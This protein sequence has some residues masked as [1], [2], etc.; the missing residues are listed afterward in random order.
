[1]TAYGLLKLGFILFAALGGLSIVLSLIFLKRLTVLSKIVAVMLLSTA[2]FVLYVKVIE[3][4]WIQVTR[5]SIEDEG[6]QR[7]AKDLTI[8]QISDIHLHA[9]IGWRE[10][11][12]VSM[13]N[14]LEPDIILFTG[15]LMDDRDQLSDAV[16]L[17]GGLR[18]KIGVFGVAGDT[19]HIVMS[20]REFQSHMKRANMDVLIN[21]GRNIKLPN[22]KIL[23]LVGL[24]DA[25]RDV[26]SMQRALESV[27]HGVFKIV[28]A[29][30]P[31]VF[32]LVSQYGPSLLL[33][34]DTHGGQ[35]G[36][37]FLI[38]ASD[39]AY[40][41]PYMRGLFEKAGTKMYVNRGIGMTTL[42]LRF[43]CRPE[44]LEI[45]SD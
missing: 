18:A 9:G 7:V 10:N 28:I 2:L 21:E 31:D 5:L 17:I 34:G 41:T 37:D 4:N 6:F 27:P 26:P 12:M 13:V 29:P 33:V 1:V 24:D 23:W 42:Y 19:D 45:Q 40:R 22:G 39:Y 3:P 32:D 16:E 11:R 35:I 38:R 43:L 30:G 14:N 36:I 15:D 25:M 44:I 8:V 20:A